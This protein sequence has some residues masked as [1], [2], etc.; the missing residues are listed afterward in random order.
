MLMNNCSFKFGVFHRKVIFITIISVVLLCGCGKKLNGI[1]N[2]ELPVESISQKLV[3]VTD[4][5][6]PEDK[7]LHMSCPYY[8]R[9]GG[10]LLQVR[11]T[12]AI[13]SDFSEYKEGTVSEC[14]GYNWIV[15]TEDGQTNYA[16]YLGCDYAFSDGVWYLYY[17]YC[18]RKLAP[19]E[20]SNYEN[21]Q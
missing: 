5:P 6:M 19:D 16:P 14:T 15:P 2:T 4:T 7:E 9:L 17:N 21:A 18:W 20:P 8:V 13:N 12:M 3:M 1:G 10:E 11:E